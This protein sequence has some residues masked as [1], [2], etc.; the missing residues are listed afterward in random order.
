MRA[1]VL[2]AALA[3]LALAVWLWGLGGA[4]DVSGWATEGQREVQAAMAGALRALRAGEPGALIGLWGLC[5]AYGFLHAAGPGHGKLLI[6]GYGLGTRVPA[7]RLSGLAL[8]ASLAQAATAVALVYAGV[9]AL[10]LTRE[11]MVGV[12]DRIMAPASY[13]AIGAVGL[14]L[15]WRGLRRFRAMWR[16]QDAHR[17]VPA[18]DGTCQSCGHRHGPT[19]EEAAQVHGVKEALA[20]IAAVTIRPCTGALFLL[21]LT[22]RMGIDMAGIIGAFVMA[23]GTA[24]VTVAVALAAVTMRTGLVG[25]LSIDGG[26]AARALPLLEAAIGALIAAV[27]LHLL[28]GAL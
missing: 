15:V 4:Q 11:A 6:G 22:W 14:W 2:S 1:L 17:H 13:A 19:A 8:A 3:L 24:S 21:I 23:L 27:A 26:I 7:L 12:A 18:P 20:L 25:R 10:D 16:R 9:L 5:F 28:R